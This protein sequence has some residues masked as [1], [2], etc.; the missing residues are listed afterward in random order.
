VVIPV[1]LLII[2]A[3]PD[4][5]SYSRRMRDTVIEAARG[6]GHAVELSDLYAM[7]FNPVPGWHDFRGGPGE[8]FFS[9]TQEQLKA[10]QTGSFAPDIAAEQAKLTECDALILIFPLWWYGLPAIMKGWVDRVFAAGFAYGNGRWFARGPFFGKRA[11]LV[12]STG[13]RASAYGTDGLQGDIHAILWPIH[14]GILQYTG[15]GVL[16]PFVA[17]AADDAERTALLAA[18]ADRVATLTTDVPLPFPRLEEFD[19]HGVRRPA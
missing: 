3:H 9:Y 10:S 16:P 8:G 5:D 12:L 7:Q 1:R 18:L 17:F 4:T 14:R 15:F 13:G 2:Y 6:V 19:D 11:M